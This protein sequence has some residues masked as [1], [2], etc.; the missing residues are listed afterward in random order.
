MRRGDAV[1]L[2]FDGIRGDTSGPSAR[3]LFLHTDLVFKPR[4][5]P[6]AGATDLTTQV[7]PLPYHG[8]TRYGAGAS[9]AYPIDEAH[10]RYYATYNTRVCGPR[11]EWGHSAE[12][13]WRS[14]RAA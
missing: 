2:D 12:L 7:G 6:G 4:T 10:R 1:E 11:S 5:L 9:G 13:R 14:K 8:M 3:S